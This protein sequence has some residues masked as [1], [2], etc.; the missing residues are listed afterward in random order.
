MLGPHLSLDC[1]FFS[2]PLVFFFISA[3]FAFVI[4]GS[5]MRMLPNSP[6]PLPF[7]EGVSSFLHLTR[8]LLNYSTGF[9]YHRRSCMDL[10]LPF[11]PRFFYR[12][13]S[14]FLSPSLRLEVQLSL[15]FPFI[16]CVKFDPIFFLPTLF[17]A[18]Y[19]TVR[20]FFY[21]SLYC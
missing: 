15:L 6:P 17:E 13:I 3:Q 16:D 19:L 8:S 18:P 2:C 20:D 14:I 9:I 7:R 1:F 11:S 4:L 21:F 12:S 10:G 5:R